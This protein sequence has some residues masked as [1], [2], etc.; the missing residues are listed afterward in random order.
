MSNAKGEK[1][2]PALQNEW[3]YSHRPQVVQDHLGRKLR[4]MYEQMP[5]QPV[6]EDVAEL[7]RRL[8]AVLSDPKLPPDAA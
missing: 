8:D 6:P 3:T 2:V 1:P 4:T 5:T 7:L